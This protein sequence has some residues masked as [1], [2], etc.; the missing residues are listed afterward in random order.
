MGAGRP[1]NEGKVISKAGDMRRADVDYVF[2]L[3]LPEEGMEG[4][5]GAGMMMGD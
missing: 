1:D 5:K 2:G 4:G 3:C